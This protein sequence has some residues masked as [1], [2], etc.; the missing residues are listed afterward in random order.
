MRKL[1]DEC[2]GC[3]DLGLPCFGDSCPNRNVTRFYCDRCGE[4]DTLYHYDEYTELCQDCLLKEF[5]I[6]EGSELYY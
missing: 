6:V 1:E 4:E 2:V 5:S 3:K